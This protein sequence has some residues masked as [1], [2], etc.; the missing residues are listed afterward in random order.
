[1]DAAGLFTHSHDLN[2]LF[3]LLRYLFLKQTKL[4]DKQ[5][6]NVFSVVDLTGV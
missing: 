6:H 5:R 4:Q 3:Q 1:M 2:K